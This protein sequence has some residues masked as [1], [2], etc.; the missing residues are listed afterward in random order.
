MFPQTLTGIQL[1]FS[2]PERPRAIGLYAIA[3]SSGAVIGQILGGAL[4]AANLAGT[5]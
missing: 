3:L 1:N 5:Q 2:G 4:I